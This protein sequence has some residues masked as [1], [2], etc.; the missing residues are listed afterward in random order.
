VPL[1]CAEPIPHQAGS[2]PK[3]RLPELRP[4]RPLRILIAEDEEDNRTLLRHYLRGHPYDI[5]FVENGEQALNAVKTPEDFDLILMDM[6]MPVMDGHTALRKIRQWED[7][8]Q[9]STVPIVALSA[10]V[11]VDEVRACLDEGCIAHVAKPVD[12][13]TLIET[14]DRYSRGSSRAGQPAVSGDVQALVRGY[15]GS[16]PRQIEEA[17]GHLN[18]RDFEL[19]RRFGHN[20]KGTGRGY[21]FPE[22]EEAGRWIEKAAK[23]ANEAEIAQQLHALRGVVSASQVLAE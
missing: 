23:E 10:S 17:F 14:I 8:S 13:A 18:S 7:A 15:L 22:I 4:L 9:R 16:K 5:Q 3:R 12:Q 6:D 21:G 11:I 1:V 2:R 19:I 20:L